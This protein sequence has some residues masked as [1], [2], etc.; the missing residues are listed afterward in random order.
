[1]RWTMRRLLYHTVKF[2]TVVYEDQHSV[3]FFLLYHQQT[4]N[5]NRPNINIPSQKGRAGAGEKTRQQRALAALPGW[6]KDSQ[7]PHQQLPAILGRGAPT[8][9][10]GLHEHF[11]DMV[12]MSPRTP[13]WKSVCTPT[14]LSLSL[15]GKIQTDV[16]LQ[17]SKLEKK[18]QTLLLI[19]LEVI[20]IFWGV[21]YQTHGNSFL[22]SYCRMKLTTDKNINFLGSDGNDAPDCKWKLYF[23]QPLNVHTCHTNK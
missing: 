17:I 4:L 23:T 5:K 14:T 2:Q 3:G 7:H 11:T 16:H 20:F 22:K 10:W 21:C 12:H 13:L 1:M 8:P 9:V 15:T 6:E 19:E 18:G